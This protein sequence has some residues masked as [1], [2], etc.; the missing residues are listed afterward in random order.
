MDAETR[1]C[2]CC[3]K[4][5]PVDNFYKDGTDKHGKIKYRRDCKN[6]YRLTRLTERQNKRK[7][8]EDAVKAEAKALARAAKKKKKG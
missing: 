2:G 8:R 7:A 6:C 3:E 5:L 4:E 1:V